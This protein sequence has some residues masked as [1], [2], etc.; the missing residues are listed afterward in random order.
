MVIQILYAQS[1]I[2]SEDQ[3]GKITLKGTYVVIGF[4]RQLKIQPRPYKHAGHQ[5]E[6]YLAVRH[7]LGGT[8][9]SFG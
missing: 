2:E 6:S 5:G 8:F 3:L 4:I 7:L 9:F 1:I